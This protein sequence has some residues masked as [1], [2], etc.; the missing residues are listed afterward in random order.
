LSMIKGM[1]EK[2]TKPEPEFNFDFNLN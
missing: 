1:I 2:E